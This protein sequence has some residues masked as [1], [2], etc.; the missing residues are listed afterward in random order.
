MDNS[1]TSIDVLV[2]DDVNLLDVA[3]P[4]QAFHAANRFADEPYVLRY[5]S[6]DGDS[7]TA[8]CGLRLQADAE[9][10]IKSHATDLIVPGG[11]GIDSL[12]LIH[13][14]NPLLTKWQATRPT[15]RLISICSGAL[16]LANAGVLDGVEATTHWSRERQALAAFP[17]VLWKL[18]ALYLQSGNIFTS[19]GVT[20]GIDL[21]LSIIRSDC[22]PNI[23]LSV[24]RELVVYLQRSGGQ[25]QY[26]DLLE[27]QF[28]TSGTIQKLIE[29]IVASPNKTWN[30]ETMADSVS[31]TPRTLS[32]RFNTELGCSPVRYLEK[33]R[34][35]SASDAIAAGMAIPKA[36]SRFG[37]G[38]FQQM[39]RAFKRNLGTTVGAFEKRFSHVMTEH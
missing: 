5:V 11:R 26:S 9:A 20:T 30:L 16:L 17:D 1:K 19:A 35:K 10:S 7:V 2:F 31:L 28:T 24:A 33:L 8:S 13:Q 39:Q 15:G 21:A 14:L 29:T 6:L 38:D 12:L 37:F 25:S 22:G 27:S 4:V 32:R 36:T 23:A 34:V 18:N 3:G